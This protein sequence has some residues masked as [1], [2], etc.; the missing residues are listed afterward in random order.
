[1]K[2]FLRCAL[3]AAAALALPGAACAQTFTFKMSSPTIN[4]VTHEWMKAFKASVEERSKG[5]IKVEMYPASQLGQI[6]ATVEG[7][8]MG[9]IELTFPVIG[10]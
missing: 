4:D 9:T 7:V 6:P 10:F 2:S 8:A 3:L 1:M 5:R